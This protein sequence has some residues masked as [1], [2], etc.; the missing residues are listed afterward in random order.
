MLIKSMILLVF[1]HT[2]ADYVFQ[3]PALVERKRSEDLR[4]YFFHV[5]VFFVFAGLFTFAWLDWR[6]TVVIAVL[7]I[8]HGI[9]DWVKIFWQ[10]KKPA[11][12]F[13]LESGDLV[14][15]LSMIVGAV[16]LFASFIPEVNKSSILKTIY[17]QNI[18]LEIALYGSAFAFI[19]RGGTALVRSLL[20]QIGKMPPKQ[21]HLIGFLSDS[22]AEESTNGGGKEYNVGRVIGN[23]ERALLLIFTIAGNYAA[24]GFVIAAKSV[25]RFKD[26][27]DHNFAEYYLV[28][29]LISTFIAIITGLVVLNVEKL[30][31][32]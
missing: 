23:L 16:I 27:E 25:A 8:V 17:A 4:A 14:L 22:E 29:T 30:L 31:N 24:I 9:Q 28:G 6:W 10:K 2:L 7:T 12:G 18:F 11:I 1:A 32:L 20:D 13:W 15:H 3:W 5:L 26:L 21:S 19:I